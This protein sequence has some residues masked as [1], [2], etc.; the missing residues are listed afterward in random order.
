MKEFFKYTL[1]TIVG[2]ITL[3]IITGIFGLISIVGMISSSEASQ[4]IND[5]SVFVLKLSGNLEERSEDDILSQFSDDINTIGLDDILSAIKKAKTND[6][7]KGIYIEAGSTFMPDSYASLQAIRDA[8][9]DFKKSGKWIVAYGDIYTQGSYYVCSVANK[10]Y[11]NPV[12]MIDWHGLGGEPYYLKDML[13]KFGIKVQLFKVGTYKSMPETY[14]AD[15]MSDA[16]RQQVTEYITGIWNHVCND[17]S[18]SRNIST[19]QLNKYADN[20]II[21]ADAKDY[22]KNRLVDGLLYNE[23]IKDEIKARLKID[24]SKTISQLSLAQ[25]D[26]VKE[27]KHD[28]DEIAVYY[29]YG[30]VVSSDLASINGACINSEQVDRDLEKLMN[31]DDVKAVVIRVNS[32]GGSSFASEQIWHAVELLK[33]KKPVVISMGGMAASGAYYLSC[34]ANWIVAEPTTLTG[35]IGIFGMIPDVS[36]L[37]TQK[38]GIKFDVVKTNKSSDFGSIG[39]PFN[40]DESRAFQASIDRGYSL[41]RSRVAQGRKM[42]VEDVEKIAQGHVWLGETA[43]KLHL[44]DQLGDL[45]TAI[46]KAAKLAKIDKSG[47]YTDSYPEKTDWM[48]K[49]LNS[50]SNSNNNYLNEQLR[51][52]LGEYYIPLMTIKNLGKQDRIQ[53]R[54]PYAVNIK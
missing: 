10:V 28:G 6:K 48:D 50:S 27:E 40:V 29:A 24:K 2:I 54:I 37:L 45:N 47:Y 13:A 52:T 20:Y 14:T 31:D 53:A 22:V 8:L 4:T 16:N 5:N 3:A 25:M 34:G 12:G 11:L 46:A 44:I 32:G 21:M 19:E 30:D 36:E 39:R 42:K 23:Q 35:S 17:V 41:F 26:N 7:I 38:I 18:E 43:L 1:A 51:L 49:L 15:K 9:K 33:A